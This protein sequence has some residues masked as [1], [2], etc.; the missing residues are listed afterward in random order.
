MAVSAGGGGSEWS[1]ADESDE[2]YGDDV[3]ECSVSKCIESCFD[4]E[5]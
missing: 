4:V 1:S 5:H 2:M 3:M